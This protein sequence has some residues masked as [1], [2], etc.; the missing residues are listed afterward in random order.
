MSL[1]NHCGTCGHFGTELP[2]QQL[3]QIRVNPE[4][5][6]DVVAGCHSPEVANLHLQVSPQG[7]CDA[8]TPAA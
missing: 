3:I 6:A 4:E 7:S 5:S 8:W 2:H 1:N